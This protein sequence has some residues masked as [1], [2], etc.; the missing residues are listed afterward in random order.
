MP[1]AGSVSRVARIMA[2][3]EV[4]GRDKGLRGASSAWMAAWVLATGY[5]YLKRMTA[6]DPVVVRERLEPGQQLVISHF[7]ADASPEPLP[8]ARRRRRR[9]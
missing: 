1:D 2:F 8:E 7:P 3:A 6:P 4:R 9:R 5:R